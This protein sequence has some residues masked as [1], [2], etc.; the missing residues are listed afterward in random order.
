[1]DK[2]M[3]KCKFKDENGNEW[4]ILEVYEIGKNKFYKRKKIGEKYNEELY[5][6]DHLGMNEAI[7]ENEVFLNLKKLVPKS[8][9]EINFCY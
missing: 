5:V 9:D 2:S 7:K 1:M 3:N 6:G 8:G 4:E